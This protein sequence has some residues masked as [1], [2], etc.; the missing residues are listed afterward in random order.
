MEF[1]TQINKQTNYSEVDDVNGKLRSTSEKQYGD[2][3]EKF[4]DQNGNAKLGQANW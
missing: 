1:V 2:W 4:D 3:D